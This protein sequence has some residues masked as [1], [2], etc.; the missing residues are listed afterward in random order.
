MKIELKLFATIAKYLP[1]SA[2]NF[3][4]EDGSTIR[5]IVA[6]LDIPDSEVKLTFVNGIQQGLDHVLNDGDRLGIFPPVGGG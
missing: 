3:V 6:K 1:D 5:A 4:V 2:N